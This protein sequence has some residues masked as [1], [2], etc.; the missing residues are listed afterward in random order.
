MI[1]LTATHRIE[2][3]L[4]VEVAPRVFVVADPKVEG[5]SL[6][7]RF[8]AVKGGGDES[9]EIVAYEGDE[10]VEVSEKHLEE[11]ARASRAQ[12]GLIADSE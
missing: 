1:E 4:A 11:A 3:H 12:A 8:A 5:G 7:T 10:M 9:L 2:G 6:I